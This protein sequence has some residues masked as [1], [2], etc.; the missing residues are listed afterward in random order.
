MKPPAAPQVP[1]AWA[2][3]AAAALA[4][5]PAHDVQTLYEQ[6]QNKDLEVRQDAQEKLEAIVRKG[7]YEVFVKGV[8]SPMKVYRAPAILDL[9]RME[10]PAARAALRDLLRA[11]RRE[12]IP[13]NPIR[14][15]PSSEE[16]DSR[17]L[18]AHLIHARGGDPEALK[19]LL[20]GA[21]GQS[22]EVLAGTCYA[23]GALRDAG[24]IRFLAG[25]ARHPD[26]EVA[27]AAVQALGTFRAPGAIEGLKPLLTHPS[28]EVRS[29]VLSA[30]QVQE[31]PM[32]I[33]LFKTMAGSDPSPDIRAAATGQLS[34]FK[35]DAA[36]SFLIEQLKSR[37]PAA[38]QNALGALRNMSGR[39]FGPRPD[40]WAR[41]WD[42]TQRPLASRH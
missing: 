18:V 6:L 21:E 3:V 14:M 5:A 2:F 22:A 23:L 27:R 11:E 41:W 30:L 42:E 26:A 31:D 20:D 9:A 37:D 1:V 17:I 10:Q 19:L 28:V 38:R 13:Y 7:D 40:Q 33:D 39:S 4:C 15:K 24:A 16:T 34:R 12:S 29:E 25:A 35:E 8:S 36:V 32:V